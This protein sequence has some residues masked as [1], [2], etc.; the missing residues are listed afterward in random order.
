M[1]GQGSY[2]L[3]QE[4]DN[5]TFSGSGYACEVRGLFDAYYDSDDDSVIAS[6]FEAMGGEVFIGGKLIDW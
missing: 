3:V 5:G 4:A 1:S 2:T 6:G